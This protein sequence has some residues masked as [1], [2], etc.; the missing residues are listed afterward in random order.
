M[1]ESKT[2]C[3]KFSA[4]VVMLHIFPARYISMQVDIIS[5]TIVDRSESSQIP[6]P[7]S[8]VPED[9]TSVNLIQLNVIR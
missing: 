8:V 4:H 5:D 7:W 3:D 6:V 1:Y 9:N 2:I